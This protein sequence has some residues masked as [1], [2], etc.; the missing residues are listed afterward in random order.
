MDISERSIHKVESH[1]QALSA[2]Y[3]D[4][5]RIEKTWNVSLSTYRGIVERFE[6]GGF[7]GAGVW[8]TN[9]PGAVLL[10]R[11]EGD[12]GWSDPGGKVEGG[13]SFEEGAKREVREETG[14]QC[15]LTGLCEVH[16]ITHR[17]DNTDV[18]PIHAPIVIFHGEYVSGDPRPREGEIEEVGWFREPPANVL[19]EEVRT[20][21]YPA[22]D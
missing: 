10:V 15:R 4:F 18:P 16:I 1:L 20:R 21:P 19:Y 8:I 9:E 6:Q 7:G 14:V 12:E 3:G 2:E 5:E 11:N 13:E 17:P 22:C